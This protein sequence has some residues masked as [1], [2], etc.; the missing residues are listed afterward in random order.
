MKTCKKCKITKD[1][2]EFPDN[3]SGAGD[4]KRSDCRACSALYQKDYRERNIM[5]TE[6]R[7]KMESRRAAKIL[8]KHDFDIDTISKIF[9]V[10][11]Y[12]AKNLI[13]K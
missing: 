9:K 2:T 4:G 12:I 11:Y 1:L 3:C 10:H 5:I 8:L 13:E 6:D 7:I